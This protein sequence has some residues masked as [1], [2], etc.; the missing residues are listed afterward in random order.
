MSVWDN[1]RRE[2]R[3]VDPAPRLIISSLPPLNERLRPGVRPRGA[4]CFLTKHI[5]RNRLEL[6]SV[7]VS[8]KMGIWHAQTGKLKET[9]ELAPWP[10]SKDA[11]PLRQVRYSPDGRYLAASSMG[12]SHLSIFDAGSWDTKRE[13][14][15]SDVL[16][17]EPHDD[18]YVDF[19]PSSELLAM[20][21]GQ[22]HQS[23][24]GSLAPL[25][26]YHVG[27]EC[28]VHKTQRRGFSSLAIAFPP[29]GK[30]SAVDGQ[31]QGSS[32]WHTHVFF[33]S[34]GAFT[35]FD[36]ETGQ[37]RRAFRG[38]A[39]YLTNLCW[40][41]DS[42]FIYS[43]A[44]DGKI[45]RWAA[46][47]GVPPASTDPV[48]FARGG[49]SYSSMDLSPDGT[50]VAATRTPAEIILWGMADRSFGLVS[51]GVHSLRKTA[52]ALDGRSLIVAYAT[53]K[54]LGR[55]YLKKVGLWK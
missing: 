40:S 28:F 44:M 27:E 29:N 35:L 19:D 21:V 20:S 15:I 50:M 11:V 24:H 48:L 34:R 54:E 26:I 30:A 43:S 33:S 17:Y 47:S 45:C 7:H 2:L 22:K 13:L 36:A 6:V 18:A 5:V 42:R 1:P 4:Q 46:D 52:F 49:R 12:S 31:A 25:G 9:V 10:H 53:K 32:S 16:K 8:G 39:D 23:H 3:R 37:P 51:A 14:K 38:H 41:S 55:C